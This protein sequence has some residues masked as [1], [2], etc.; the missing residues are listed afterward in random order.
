ESRAVLGVP[1]AYH[2]PSTPGAAYLKSASGDLVRF[3]TAFV[4]GHD[5]ERHSAHLSTTS[6][7][8]LLFTASRVGTV[9]EPAHEGR[10]QQQ[11]R[12]VLDTVLDRLA[13]HG[14][15]AHQVWL[16]PLTESPTLDMLTLGAERRG[17][18]VPIGV[19]DNP[20][21]QRRDLLVVELDGPAGNVAIAGAPRAGKST[22][23]RTMMLA[24]AQHH[25]P[26][27]VGFYCL[28][29]GGGALSSLRGLP[30][31]GSM[32]GRRDTELCRRTV[33][34]VGAV[35]R[36]RELSFRRM[37]I[38][39]MADYRRA[40]AAG[41][42]DVADD[43]F[44][45][46]FLVVDGWATLRQE[47][48]LLEGPITAIAA[49]G[50]SFGV[51]VV[52]T[53][54][55][56][57]ELRPALKDQIATRIELRLGDP[58]E[59]EMDRKRARD[60]SD[61]PPGRGIAANRREFAIALPR[62]DGN[63][64]ANGLAEAIA[65]DT[66][67]LRDR[68]APS[69]APLVQLLPMR[70]QRDNL[71]VGDGDALESRVLIGIG[72]D[73]LKSIHL[74]FAEQSHLLVLGEARCGKTA[75]LRLLCREL[76]RTNTADEA[77]L[78]IVDFRRTLL[79]VVESEHLTGYAMSPASLASRLPVII[80]R[81]QGRMPG[82]DITQQQL[83]TRSWWSGPD[84]Y[85][86]IDDYDLAAGA[87]GSPLARLVDFLPHAKDLGLH[88]VVARRSGGAARAMFD[89]V[90]ASMRELGCMGLM[91]SASPEEGV[92]LG[93]VRP[94]VMPPGRGTLITRSGADQLIQ[95]AWTDPP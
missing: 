21:E 33:A 47:F 80:D 70:V 95:V 65:A 61:R 15:L 58:A 74:D 27:E 85:L 18:T 87:T 91:M 19:V 2:L 3:Q 13:G 20:Y 84:I 8:P 24:L 32:A 59:S 36:A 69:T 73:E 26:A 54:S 56:W 38:D 57:A 50:L 92:L 34:V 62:W 81:L 64:T 75:L 45:D 63:P 88:V 48:D 89:P 44:G 68:W 25:D 78:E 6:T 5:G 35:I 83:R 66:E 9:S 76:V 51:H 22:A 77:Q 40:R 43:P 42:S 93:A 14:P 41:D 71:V 31:V 52:V 1:D 72:E 17:L 23:L 90:L 28:D 49:Q 12:T 29:F 11:V 46:V 60:L 79:G 39:A 4:S 94:S 67:R 37:G 30:H 86:V 10:P 16:P 82:E 7:R 55:R 53:A